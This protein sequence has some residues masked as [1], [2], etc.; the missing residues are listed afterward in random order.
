LHLQGSGGFGGN[1]A[2]G[3]MPQQ[4]MGNQPMG[5]QQQML[6]Q[7]ANFSQLQGGG[8]LSQ[9]QSLQGNRMMGLQQQTQA[10][11]G[12]SV[13]SGVNMAALSRISNLTSML[14]S[15]NAGNAMNNMGQNAG[16]KSNMAAAALNTNSNDTNEWD[17]FFSQ[18]SAGSSNQNQQQSSMR[19]NFNQSQMQ[20]RRSKSVMF[21]L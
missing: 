17:Q 4:G 16:F 18:A 11:A 9:Q 20:V 14:A 6:Q 21:T 12:G 13:N 10:M 8:G 5:L 15:S 1:A 2:G 3:M 7:K 19:G